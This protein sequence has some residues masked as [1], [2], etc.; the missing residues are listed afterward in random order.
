MAPSVDGSD[1]LVGIGGPGERLWVMVGVREVAVDG[2]LKVDD[3][4]EDAALQAALGQ[5][6]EEGL[7]RVE[8]G[9]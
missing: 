1:D 5:R 8:P 9:A 3:R 6:R 4:S 2:G 7:D